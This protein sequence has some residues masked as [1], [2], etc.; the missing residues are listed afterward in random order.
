MIIKRKYEK[1]GT[2]IERD[3]EAKDII[4]LVLSGKYNE[5][6]I[7]Y[8]IESNTNNSVIKSSNISSRVLNELIKKLEKLDKKRP[9]NNHVEDLDCFMRDLHRY[10]NSAL[11]KLYEN[12]KYLIDNRPFNGPDENDDNHHVGERAIV[13][14]FAYYL[15]ELLYK[16][17]FFKNYNLDCEYNRN[18]YKAKSLPEFPKGTY[19]DVILH[20]RG[21]NDDNLLVM[22]FKTYWNENQEIDKEKIRGFTDCRGDY[23]FHYGVA[24]MI[25]EER[26]NVHILDFID[27]HVL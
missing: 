18:G 5:E 25:K 17:D 16:D 19:P 20:K 21:T 2:L 12:D 3:S 14:R 26:E 8:I 15:Q 4:K 22:E 9:Y 1:I 27:G 13:F 11:D 6:E 23:W 10:I 7:N 24:I